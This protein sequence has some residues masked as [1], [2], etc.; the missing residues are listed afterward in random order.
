MF[1]HKVICLNHINK[2]IQ[3]HFETH[4]NNK[5]NFLDLTFTIIK[6]RF[7]FNIHRKCIQTDTLIPYD[8]NQLYK[9][10]FFYQCFIDANEFL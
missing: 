5:I 6:N 1:Y 7:E 9:N 3:F 4:I 8:S 2:N 10:V